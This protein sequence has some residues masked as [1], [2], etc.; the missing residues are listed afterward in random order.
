[1]RDFLMGEDAGPVASTDPLAALL[2]GEAVVETPE[3]PAAEEGD[4]GVD[5]AVTESAVPVVEEPV[6]ASGADLEPAEEIATEPQALPEVVEEATGSEGISQIPGEEE[7][8][9]GDEQVQ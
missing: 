6:E 2:G 3:A 8:K 9:S 4:S 1:L 5:L 7:S